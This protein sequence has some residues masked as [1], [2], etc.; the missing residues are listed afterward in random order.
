M[1]KRGEFLFSNFKLFQWNAHAA[2]RRRVLY[3]YLCDS[4]AVYNIYMY[5]CIYVGTFTRKQHF[6]DGGKPPSTVRERVRFSSGCKAPG[7]VQV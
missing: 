1:A 6:V 5:I 3:S 2:G 7:K 4:L